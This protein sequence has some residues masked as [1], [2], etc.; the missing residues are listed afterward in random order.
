MDHVTESIKNTLVVEASR[1]EVELV[2]N[3]IEKE[4]PRLTE[5]HKTTKAIVERL[6][7]RD[8]TEF[9]KMASTQRSGQ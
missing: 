7:Q 8:P 5:L 2:E 9:E 3:L 6:L 4:S 1:P